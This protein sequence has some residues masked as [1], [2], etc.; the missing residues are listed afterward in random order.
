MGDG[1]AGNVG[2]FWRWNLMEMIWQQWQASDTGFD[3]G[4]F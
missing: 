3:D 2:G 1:G 4:G